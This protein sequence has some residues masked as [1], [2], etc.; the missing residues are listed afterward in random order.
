[1][2]A[3]ERERES[4]NLIL[5]PPSRSRFLFLFFFFFFF[6]PF[7]SSLFHYQINQ[8]F[9]VNQHTVVPHL[10]SSFR[11]KERI[12]ECSRRRFE[13]RGEP[14]KKR[15]KRSKKRK[16]FPSHFLIGGVVELERERASLALSFLSS[17]RNRDAPLF[18]RAVPPRRSFQ[19]PLSLAR[20]TPETVLC[21][22]ATS[23]WPSET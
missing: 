22:S 16:T 10:I 2:R 20:K 3:R 21:T 5:L 12:W 17:A 4:W 1:M 7:S 18:A 15:E 8:F 19:G 11:K 6:F 14:G 23:G 9:C 13:Q